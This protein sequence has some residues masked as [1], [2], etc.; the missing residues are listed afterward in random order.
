MPKLDILV[1]SATTADVLI[2]WVQGAISQAVTSGTHYWLVV[3]AGGT[4]N[5]TSIGRSR[6]QSGL[7]TTA[8]STFTTAP[9]AL[10]LMLLSGAGCGR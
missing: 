2:E 9:S 1:D 3:Y 5:D 4:D 8:R 7:D 10:I 6:L